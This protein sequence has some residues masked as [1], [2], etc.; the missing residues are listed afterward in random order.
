MK[1]WLF[2]TALGMSFTVNAATLQPEAGLSVLF[3]NG[4]ET[5][6]SVGEQTIDSGE[7]ELIVRMDKQVGRGSSDNVFT[8]SPYVVK[9]VV[10]DELVKMKLPQARSMTEAEKAFS[11][12]EPQWVI[13]QDGKATNYQ[14]EL[15]PP[16]D[17][18]FPYLGLNTLVAD[19]YSAKNNAVTKEQAVVLNTAAVN[20]VSG[21]NTTQSTSNLVQLKAWYLKSST[22]ERKAFR[23]WM[24][25]QE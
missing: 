20:N 4:N 8:S 24:I 14:Q 1:Q 10:T 23:R 25:D 17:G 19:Y 6:S 9:F 13:L 5:K 2:L 21:I 7:V 11:S 16:K 15:L 22:E 18:L 12:N 3:I